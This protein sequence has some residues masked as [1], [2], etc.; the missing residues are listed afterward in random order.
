M[1][2]TKG[3]K[4]SKPF[5]DI[6]RQNMAAA[7]IGKPG[8]ASRPVVILSIEY[9]STVVASRI[10]NLTTACIFGRLNSKQSKWIDWTY[11]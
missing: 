9:P 1:S 8:A 10:L 3:S 7:K 4:N 11:K 6:A 2:R 5:T